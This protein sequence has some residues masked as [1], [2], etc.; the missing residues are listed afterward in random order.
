MIGDLEERE[1]HMGSLSSFTIITLKDMAH[2]AY[3]N[4]R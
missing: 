3:R 2:L 1:M 4:Q